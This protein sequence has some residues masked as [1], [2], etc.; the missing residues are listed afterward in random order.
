MVEEGELQL[1][2]LRGLVIARILSRIGATS[3]AEEPVL[4]QVL[5]VPESKK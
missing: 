2:A 1:P 4:S 3:Q 5:A